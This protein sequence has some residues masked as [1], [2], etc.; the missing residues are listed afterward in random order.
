MCSYA[1]RTATL[2]VHIEGRRADNTT[3]LL[4]VLTCQ[5][6]IDHEKTSA[7]NVYGLESTTSAAE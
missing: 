6:M 3:Y 2:Y 5:R 1:S 4:A 7:E